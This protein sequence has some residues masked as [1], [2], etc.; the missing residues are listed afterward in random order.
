MTLHLDVV[1][2]KLLQKFLPSYFQFLFLSL[3]RPVIKSEDD[4]FRSTG[5]NN[6]E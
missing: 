2:V 4:T 6:Y 3:H 1:T 5:L